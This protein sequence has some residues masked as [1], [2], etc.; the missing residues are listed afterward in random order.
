MLRKLV[1]AGGLFVSLTAVAAAK[2]YQVACTKRL[3]AAWA[4]PRRLSSS[5]I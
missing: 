5:T 4:E 3:F 1:V 2:T